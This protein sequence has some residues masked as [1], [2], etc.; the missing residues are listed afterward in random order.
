VDRE[1]AKYMFG[2]SN[3]ASCFVEESTH[4]QV[5]VECSRRSKLLVGSL[6]HSM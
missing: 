5:E 1:P 6:L 4:E 3:E 2:M